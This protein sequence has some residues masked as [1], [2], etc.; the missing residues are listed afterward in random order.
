MSDQI[1]NTVGTAS[2]AVSSITTPAAVPTPPAPAAAVPP[3]AEVVSAPPPTQ[4]APAPA[5]APTPEVVPVPVAKPVTDAAASAVAPV[6]QAAAPVQQAAAPVQQAA[7]AAPPSAAKSLDSAVP[8]TPA[9]VGSTA[10]AAVAG[11]K[12]KVSDA[13]ASVGTGHSG[14]GSNGISD[15]LG[16][17]LSDT[18]DAISD[19][20]GTVS[21]ASAAVSQTLSGAQAAAGSTLPID[22][23]A[24]AS[25]PASSASTVAS[26]ADAV[27][28]AARDSAADLGIGVSPPGAGDL[29]GVPV[30]AGSP[31]THGI[32][33]PGVAETVVPTDG[34]GV[35]APVTDPFGFSSDVASLPQLAID[36]VTNPTL[37]VTAGLLTLA[38]AGVSAVGRGPGLAGC[39]SGAQ[40][41]FTNV[42]LIPCLAAQSIGQSLSHAAAAAARLPTRV[43]PAPLQP[44]VAV[45]GSGG[46]DATPSGDS[47][48]A[49][50]GPAVVSEDGRLMARI[51]AALAM[52]YAS[53]LAAWLAGTKVQW[54]PRH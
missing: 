37:V 41:V 21:G 2:E 34:N 40:L 29:L 4:A 51:G 10:D 17:V 24:A 53:F 45:A 23:S 12:A 3:P 1:T 18:S 15:G 43:M 36:G 6:Q 49:A 48:E 5:P 32:S 20:S 46:I 35:P 27:T 13:T 50:S 52:L 31:A 38:G 33:A 26:G 47:G 8:S 19:A 42:R 28:A 14:Q 25:L 30:P 7:Q 9:D 39:V 11:V 44:P 22:L 16:G 54:K